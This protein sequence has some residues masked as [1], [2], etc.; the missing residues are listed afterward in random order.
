MNFI[1]IAANK[2]L[3]LC[4]TSKLFDFYLKNITDKV[5]LIF[6]T[7][8][9]LFYSN[10]FSKAWNS[11]NKPSTFDRKWAICWLEKLKYD[12]RQSIIKQDRITIYCVD[13]IF[14]YDPIY[15]MLVLSSRLRLFVTNYVPD[16]FS[17]S[18]A[19]D[20]QRFIYEIDK[21]SSFHVNFI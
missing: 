5:N 10:I 17:L 3:I 14:I 21:V 9:H 4:Q 18:R 6:N 8:S 19:I 11:K 13:R 16:L 7:I 20:K 15:V 12:W 2:F 1:K